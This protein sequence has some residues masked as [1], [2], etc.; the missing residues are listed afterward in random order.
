M[1][2]VICLG[3]M[4]SDTFLLLDEAEILKQEHVRNKHYLIC[5]DFGDKIPI[6]KQLKFSGGSAANVAVGLA[7]LG[8]KSAIATTASKT[9]DD[10]KIIQTL[11]QEKVNIELINQG[12]HFEPHYS[13]IL[14]GPSGE[15]TILV[16]HGQQGLV[17]HDLDWITIAKSPWVY[18][19]PM[20][21]RSESIL[22]KLVE[23]AKQGIKIA[24]NPGIVQIKKGLP[25]LS[26]IFKHTQLLVLNRE[27][28]ARLVGKPDADL[29][30][31]AKTLYN[32]E[33]KVVAITDGRQGATAYDGQYLRHID[34]FPEKAKVDTTG[35][36]DAF[37]AAMISALIQSKDLET[38]LKWGVKNGASVIAE[39][40]AQTGLL[41]TDQI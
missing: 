35:A 15:R 27:E 14:V 40:G 16:Y 2:D 36:G 21:E 12:E 6:K 19:G 5:F 29:D 38:S 32:Y 10:Q 17:E 9:A 1:H 11:H 34:A 18:L 22:K 25:Y 41:R 7:R 30:F 37:I 28:A 8:L 24:Y 4:I 20:P 3:D 39:F 26:E 33:S 31:L 23:L 13:Y